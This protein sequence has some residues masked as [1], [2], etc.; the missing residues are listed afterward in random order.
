MKSPAAL[1]ETLAK[2]RIACHPAGNEDVVNASFFSRGECPFHQI[3]NHGVLKA[4]DHVNGGLRTVG[5]QLIETW[6]L[7]GLSPG[8]ALF[9]LAC[10]LSAAHTVE[11]G[12]LKTGEAEIHRI[13]PHLDVAEIHS[14]RV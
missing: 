6:T 11:H 7:H 4:R 2:Q 10:K 9:R 12:S 14:V 1:V 8:A 3:L 5:T 13:A